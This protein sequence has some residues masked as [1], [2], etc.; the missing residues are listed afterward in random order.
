M[1]EFI[2]TIDSDDEEQSSFKKTK[3]A[4][5]EALNPDFVFDAGAD[6]EDIFDGAVQDQVKAGTKTVCITLGTKS[7]R[8]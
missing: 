1:A 2:M 6:Y 3:E 7:L 4:A 8:M 5:E